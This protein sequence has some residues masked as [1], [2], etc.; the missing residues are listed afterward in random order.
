ML[1]R[2]VRGENTYPNS[3]QRELW[4]RDHPAGAV[5]TRTKAQSMVKTEQKYTGYNVFLLSY[6]LL[7][8]PVVEALAQGPSCAVCK[9][10]PHLGSEQRPK[11]MEDGCEGTRWKLKGVR[12][13]RL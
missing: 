4:R 3:L 8:P 11:E 9:G 1:F 6:L 10:K 2:S 13:I 12:S 5:V 7:V